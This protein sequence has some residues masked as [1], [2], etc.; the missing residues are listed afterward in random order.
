MKSE[1]VARRSDLIFSVSPLA[2]GAVLR[3]AGVSV[4]AVGRLIHHHLQ[5][6]SEQL[7]DDPWSRKW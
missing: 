6:V 3:I 4:E 2:V 1:P 5:P 7:G